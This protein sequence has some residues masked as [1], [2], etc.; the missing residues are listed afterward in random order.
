[1][2]SQK[3]KDFLIELQSEICFALGDNQGEIVIRDDW[4]K[5]DANRL[6]GNGSTRIIEK[7]KVFERGGVNFSDVSGSSLPSS[8]TLV[9]P[10]LKGMSF[11]AM[12]ISLVFHPKNPYV[13][14]VH[15][16][17]RFFSAGE[18]VW[19]FGG[20]IDLTPYY[21]FEDDVSHFH[22]TCKDSL[23][24]LSKKYYPKFKNNCDK[25]F[26]LKHRDEMRGVG[27]IFFDDFSELGF[28]GS[29]ELIKRVG[30]SFLPAYEP[31]VL[32][33]KTVKWGSREKE[34]QEYRRGRYV[35]FNLVY[36][37]GTLFGLQSGGRI[38]SIL[39]SMPPVAKWTYNYIPKKNSPESKLY[40]Y[41]R[42]IDWVSLGNVK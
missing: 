23:D 16:N 4:K 25:Y 26:Y 30:R 38:E 27:G 6:S 2:H 39:M 13:P 11:R 20:G 29:F 24:N 40:K 12:G 8:A 42:P 28:D 3:V 21:V 10:E 17:L 19:W 37:R 22:R 32:K 1:M 7:G 34:F 14:T 18:K 15:M 9:R 31:I 35:E 36:D 41:L 5:S 33:R